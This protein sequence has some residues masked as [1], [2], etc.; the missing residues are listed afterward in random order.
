ME[1]ALFRR[2]TDWEREFYQ[3]DNTITFESVGLTMNV[4]RRYR[5]I[6]F[7]NPQSPSGPSDENKT[8]PGV[9]SVCGPPTTAWERAAD[10]VVR[11]AQR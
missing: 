8:T 6:D 10:V 7:D 9:A 3:Q 4:S 5:G 1:L 11:Q 2:R